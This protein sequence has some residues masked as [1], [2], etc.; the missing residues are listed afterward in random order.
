MFKKL[1]SMFL[2]LLLLSCILVSCEGPQGE[3]GPQ[4]EKGDKGDNGITPTIEISEDGYWVING[5]KT[6]VLATVKEKEFVVGEEILFENGEE[7][8]LPSYYWYEGDGLVSWGVLEQCKIKAK[9]VAVEEFSLND[10]SKWPYP[11]QYR[12][13]YKYR[14]YVTGY[15]PLEHAGETCNYN[16]S[17]RTSP[18]NGA[19]YKPTANY[20]STIISDDGY[21]EFSVDVYMP[22]VVS[23]VIPI[24]LGTK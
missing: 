18:Y 13:S 1:V 23:K 20:E 21:F 14:I 12:F 24:N 15:C 17:F 9:M 19:N 22:D 2:C 16:L 7:F 3:V 5:E 10:S 8:T 6:T 4:G 11:E